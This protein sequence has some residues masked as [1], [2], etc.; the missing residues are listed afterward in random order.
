MDS[1][2]SN[3]VHLE[4]E[5]DFALHESG[6]SRYQ[7]TRHNDEPAKIRRPVILCGVCCLTF[8]T[9]E[10]LNAHKDLKH[11]FCAVCDNWYRFQ[12]GLKRHYQKAHPNWCEHCRKHLD[13]PGVKNI[14]LQICHK[15]CKHCNNYFKNLTELDNHI[16]KEH[17][18]PIPAP[19]A[20]QPVVGKYYTLLNVSPT[21][22]QEDV[23]RAARNARIKVHP[24]R[25]YR[26][27]L[28]QHSWAQIVEKAKEVG[29]AADVLCD[30][31]ERQKYDHSV[32][33]GRKE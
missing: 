4:V 20:K 31:C 24:D 16:A 18:A 30:V 10:E 1:M 29:C 8:T 23:L 27:G 32:K 17:T 14:H 6:R 5:L 21:A 19:V 9:R 13:S 33:K 15:Y 7:S 26:P 22:S 2:R 12:Y 11:F 3:S 25:L 28:S